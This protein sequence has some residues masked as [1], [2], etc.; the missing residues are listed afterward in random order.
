MNLGAAV[1]M[2]SNYKHIP[3]EFWHINMFSD[4]ETYTALSGPPSKMQISAT[5]GDDMDED[6]ILLN[7][8]DLD[9]VLVPQY[10]V[11]QS[12]RENTWKVIDD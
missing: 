6:W 2:R 8:K 7:L 4:K 11:S 10:L 3:R 5:H 12:K 1:I 9:L